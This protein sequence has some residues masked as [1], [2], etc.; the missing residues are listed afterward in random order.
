LLPHLFAN[1]KQF[2]KGKKQINFAVYEKVRIYFVL[3][4]RPSLVCVIAFN[5][6]SIGKGHGNFPP[7]FPSIFSSLKSEKN[8]T[9][10]D[11]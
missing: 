2:K 6:K 3:K 1:F 4:I 7:F 5:E 10:C 9:I 8:Q 11:G